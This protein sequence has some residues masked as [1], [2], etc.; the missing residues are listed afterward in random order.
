MNSHE[1]GPE[2]TGKVEHSDG[3]LCCR[4]VCF[5]ST[6]FHCLVICRGLV[7]DILRL[8]GNYPYCVVSTTTI[9]R[10]MARMHELCEKSGCLPKVC[11][12]GQRDGIAMGHPAYDQQFL[13]GMPAG[14]EE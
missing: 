12:V 5:S 2:N 8:D 14:Q 9:N 13:P 4:R 10:G 11:S 6:F 7:T 1:A 3:C